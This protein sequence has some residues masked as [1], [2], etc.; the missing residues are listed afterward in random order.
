MSTSDK[1]ESV[2]VAMSGGVDSSVTALILKQ[3]G[4]HVKGAIL[5]MHDEDMSPE[6]IS[7]GK[8]PLSI[9]H[10]REAARRMRLDFNI[11]DVRGEFRN[12]V[13]KYFVSG[14]AGG[15]TP[16]PC[17]YC[18]SRL[19]IPY[20][21]KAAKELE[22]GKIATGHYAVIEY[23]EEYKRFIMKKA[24][25]LSRDQSYMLC[26]LTQDQL[27][28]LITP[29]GG[30]EKKDIR[31]MARNA[32]LK[33]ADTP[34]SQDV[35]FIPDGDYGRFVENSLRQ[36]EGNEA[37]E[38]EIPGLVPGDFVDE[39][40]RVLGRHKGYIHYTIGQRK[41]LGLA[42]PEPLYVCEKRTGTN[43]VVLGKNEALFTDRVK[44]ADVNFVSLPS[45]P[46]GG[47]RISAKIR[48]S[49]NEAPGTA[50]MLSDGCLEVEFDEPVRA[51][52]P[53][54]SLVLYDKDMVVAGGII[55]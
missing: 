9:W 24:V 49:Q 37:G 43:Q 38:R 18:N 47:M 17:V 33:N 51:A 20:M 32:N 27:S 10:A 39:D 15:I 25:D 40:G 3:A 44:A 2:L 45:L 6:D 34:D 21:L 13:M 16:N 22:C 54:Q 35:C 5:R 52:A 4:Y 14:Y 1:K 8:L 55:V 28:R 48:Y 53:G 30:Y 36:A 46:E 41:G 23:S 19:K 7:N 50:K 29:L 42:L 11:I 12:D 31:E 26:R